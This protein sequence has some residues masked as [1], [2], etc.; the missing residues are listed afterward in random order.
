VLA[1]CLR[2]GLGAN[3]QSI[4]DR[5]KA[6]FQFDI[7]AELHALSGLGQVRLAHRQEDGSANQSKDLDLAPINVRASA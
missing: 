6:A 1:N 3:F 2:H 5:I 7:A 4:H